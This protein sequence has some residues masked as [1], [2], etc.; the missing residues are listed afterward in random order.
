MTVPEFASKMKYAK[1]LLKT[2]EISVT[3]PSRYRAI[4]AIWILKIMSSI[5]ISPAPDFLARKNR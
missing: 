5:I 4:L 3:G 1:F 2:N